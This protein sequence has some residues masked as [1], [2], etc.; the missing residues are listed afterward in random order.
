MDNLLTSKKLQLNPHGA[1]LVSTETDFEE[2]FYVSSTAR[3]GDG[4]AIRGG[5]PIIAPWFADLLGKT[6][7]H[8]WARTAEWDVKTGEEGFNATISQDGIQLELQVEER[9]NGVHLALSATNESEQPT[10]IQLAFHPY[11]R[12]THPEEVFI[13]GMEDVEVLDRFTNETSTHDGDV[14]VEGAYDRIF[15]SAEPTRIV[16]PGEGRGITIE[17]EGADTT[18]VWS[19]GEEAAADMDDIGPGEWKDFLCVEPA[20]LG[21][22]LQGVELAPGETRSL[23]MTLTATALEAS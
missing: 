15:F 23:T 11:F 14:I 18:V 6:P 7:K 10:T 19:P 16:D 3:S 13:A 12:V 4:D 1:H 17:M 5:V 9:L 20:L 21:E 22:N 8:G 2:L